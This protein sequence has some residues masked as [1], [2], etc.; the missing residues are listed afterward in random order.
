MSWLTESIMYRHGVA[1]GQVTRTHTLTEA[2][3][4]TFHYTIG[5]YSEPVLHVAPGDRIV[6]ETRDAFEGKVQT[7]QDLPTRVLLCRTNSSA[8][9]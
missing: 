3:Q 4:G 1:R 9:R 7:T 6:V 2:L 5:P 8:R